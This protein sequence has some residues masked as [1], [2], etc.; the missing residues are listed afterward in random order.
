MPGEPED[1]RAL[2]R[3]REHYVVERELADR[4]R[5]ADAR[6]RTTLYRTVY[7]ELFRRIPD[8]PQLTRA[9]NPAAQ[10][11]S[12]EGHLR[13]LTPYL[14]PGGDFLEIGAGDCQLA[15]AVARVARAVYAVDASAEITRL[16]DTPP[17]LEVLL[18]EG[19]Q[20]PPLPRQVD[21]AYSDQLLE[22]LH[23]DDVRVH[24]AGVFAAL[25]PGGRYVCLTP[26]RLNGPHDVSMYFDDIARGLH[27]R[28]YTTWELSRLLREA[29]FGRVRALIR[30]R[31]RAFPVPAWVIGGLERTLDAL[32]RKVARSLARGFPLRKIL[33]CTVVAWKPA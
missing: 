23:P 28:E 13:L 26:N 17:N 21:V 32:P 4:L 2:D 8:H 19:A 29:G 7:D 33:G 1:T 10:I 15:Y 24:I 22:H 27:L 30:T 6:E 31:T 16:T 14:E 5:A 12:V 9:N 18:A 11:E 20:V 3:I 25:R